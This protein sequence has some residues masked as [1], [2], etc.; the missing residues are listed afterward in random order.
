MEINDGDDRVECLWVRIKAKAN[1]TDI[2]VGVCYRPPNQDEEVD[3]T[4]YRQLGEVSRSLPLVL[5][6]DFNFPDICWIYNTAD[7]EQS[8]R[9]LE[10]VGDNFLTQLVKEPTKGSKILDLLF[11]NRGG[12]V[13]DVKVG[14]CLGHSDHEMLDEMLYPC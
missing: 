3:K 12:L 8:Q 13:G 9:F 5:V 10:C 6:G 14:G 11:V 1:K 4:L 7:R 2:I